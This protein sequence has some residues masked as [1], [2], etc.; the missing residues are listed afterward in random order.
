MEYYRKITADVG[1]SSD[2][3]DKQMAD[4]AIFMAK[5]NIKKLEKS[6]KNKERRLR[7]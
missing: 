5:Q 7:K 6:V 4:L 3:S 1:P 2:M